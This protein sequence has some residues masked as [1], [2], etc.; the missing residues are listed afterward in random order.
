MFKV[1]IFV[2]NECNFR[3]LQS[4]PGTP[5][6][7]NFCFR[8]IDPI[9][10]D[11]KI[12]S[13][14]VN[15]LDLIEVREPITLTGGEP[16]IS[17]HLDYLINLLVERNHRVSLNTNGLLL[18]KKEAI[19]SKIHYIC[20]P[21]DGNNAEIA[22]Y[23]RGEGYFQVSQKTFELAYKYRIPI[24]LHTLVTPHNVSKL[25]EMGTYISNQ[26]YSELIWYWYLKKFKKIN[27]STLLD[28]EPYEL[29]ENIYEQ[30]VLNVRNKFPAI[31]ISG[32]GR[33]VK[34]YTTLYIALNGNVF[35]YNKGQQT[36]TL[37]GNILYESL[38]SIILH[39]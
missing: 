10:S 32:S 34:G 18:S 9:V 1:N 2:T 29:D 36:N 33:T 23:Y 19:M 11:R 21:Y 39:I 6:V 13:K 22:D 38:D 4:V 8:P 26:R 16:L 27:N 14:V 28:T 35:I 25:E 17:E 12:I 37:I 3:L 15:S 20:L 5:G 31:N 7:C 30:A 24:G